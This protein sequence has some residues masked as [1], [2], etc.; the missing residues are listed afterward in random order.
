LSEIL[1]TK[2]TKGTKGIEKRR[3]FFFVLFV[4]FVVNQKS[5][6]MPSIL[7]LRKEFTSP[8]VAL[9]FGGMRVRPIVIPDDVDAWLALRSCATAGLSPRVREWSREYFAAQMLAKPWWRNDWTWL[10]IEPQVGESVIGAVT[11]GL[12]TGTEATVS[13]VHWLVV[14]PPWRRRG[15]GRML[16]SR[17][18][19]AAWQ[20]GYREVELET[21]ANWSEAVAFYQSMGYAP[22]R[23]R[24]PR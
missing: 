5:L 18:E 4:P 10:A 15:V 2:D 24:S 11:L 16:M 9:E 6:V 20:A 14:D 22:V 8:P 19:L 13:I 3:L 23:E 12:R 17:L 1:T 21:H 7:H